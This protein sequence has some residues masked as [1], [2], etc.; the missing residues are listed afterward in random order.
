MPYPTV[1]IPSHE[2]TWDTLTQA[3]AQLQ[4]SHV[5]G[6]LPQTRMEQFLR[7]RVDDM[8]PI[9]RSIYKVG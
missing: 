2:S 3:L 5:V 6:E 4:A 8:L 1:S 9:V 7:S